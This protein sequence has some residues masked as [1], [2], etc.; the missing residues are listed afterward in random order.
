MTP[1]AHNGPQ[2]YQNGNHRETRPASVSRKL[3][4][5]MPPKH[6][7]QRRA[8]ARRPAHGQNRPARSPGM[9]PAQAS[10]AHQSADLPGP[11]QE[12][13]VASIPAPGRRT[14]GPAATRRLIRPV[15]VPVP[16][17]REEHHC[18]CASTRAVKRHFVAASGRIRMAANRFPLARLQGIIV[19]ITSLDRRRAHL[20]RH[21]TY[22]S[23]RIA[24]S[25]STL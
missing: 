7:R 17:T 24:C 2:P 11:G 13:C 4:V 1:T 3:P 9:T 8:H 23:A 22:D 6:A 10:G 12:Y 20:A 16:M 19:R 25:A 21:L 15:S 5:C 14:P 18:R